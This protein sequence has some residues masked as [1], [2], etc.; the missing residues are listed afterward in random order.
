MYGYVF[1]A[2][3]V[4]VT[5]RVRRDVMLYPGYEPNMG[6][7]P[8]IFHYGSDYTYKLDAAHSFAAAL[9]CVRPEYTRPIHIHK[10]TPDGR[11]WLIHAERWWP[12]D[13]VA[14]QTLWTDRPAEPPRGVIMGRTVDFPR[15]QH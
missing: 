3:I 15:P 2:A 14:M 11:S 9:R 12:L 5:H 4:G 10:L 7:G 6:R 1:A 8:H 13:D